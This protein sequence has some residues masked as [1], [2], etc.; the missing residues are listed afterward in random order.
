[1]PALVEKGDDKDVEKLTGMGYL[2]KAIRRQSAPDGDA[3]LACSRHPLRRGRDDR[4]RRN[5]VGTLPHEMRSVSFP[6]ER[7]RTDGP[8]NFNSAVGA[9]ATPGTYETRVSA[10]TFSASDGVRY[11]ES[12]R[13]AAPF[14]RPFATLD[15]KAR[16]KMRIRRIPAGRCKAAPKF[17]RERDPGLA[18]PF[19]EA[20]ARP[21][22]AS[23]F[24]R[25]LIR[26]C[27]TAER[28]TA[29]PRSTAPSPP[30]PASER[31]ARH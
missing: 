24:V 30:Q 25:H 22:G 4:S 31:E 26:P 17:P 21:E 7:R 1:M 27:A 16:K 28:S 12:V 14:D 23:A 29:P 13:R 18:D 2:R 20:A 8:G 15:Q 9:I 5:R 19:R 10:K 11:R 6:G 3:P